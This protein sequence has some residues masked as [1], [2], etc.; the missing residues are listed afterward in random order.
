MDDGISHAIRAAGTSAVRKLSVRA[1]TTSTAAQLSIC[2]SSTTA[3]NRTECS[4]MPTSETEAGRAAESPTADSPTAATNNG[5]R[6]NRSGP[7]HV[8]T[9]S[10]AT[11]R[12]RR[13]AD[14]SVEGREG[15][16]QPRGVGS[17]IYARGST[18][19]GGI[20]LSAE[21]GTANASALSRTWGHARQ[22]RQGAASTYR[23]NS[24]SRGLGIWD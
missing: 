10:A 20:Y 14:A 13:A 19:A 9:A 15:W 8:T 4:K 24:R 18:G 3:A 17:T 1:S 7:S 6:A 2:R 23:R 11:H 16:A 5:S 21:W 12:M 22:K